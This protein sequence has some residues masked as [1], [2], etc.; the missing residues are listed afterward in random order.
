MHLLIALYIFFQSVLAQ[1][2]HLTT[3]YSS[4]YEP[5]CYPTCYRQPV[6]IIIDPQNLIAFVEGRNNSYCSGTADGSPSSIRLRRSN[7]GGITWSS[8]EQVLYTGKCDFLA[9]VQD[10]K[11]GRTHLFIQAPPTGSLYTYSDDKGVTW[12]SPEP[13]KIK[14]PSGYTW[15]PAVA[16]GIQISGEYCEEPTCNGLTGRLVISFVCYTKKA[17]DLQNQVES[18]TACPG[19]YTC[20]AVSDDQGATWT[21]HPEAV[22]KQEGSREASI[23]QLRSS[24]HKTK[25]PVIYATERNLG[26]DTGF[27][28]HAISV[29]G[30]TSFSIF[31]SDKE[32]PDSKVTNWTGIVAGAARVVRGEEQLVV[33]TTPMQKTARANMGIFVSSD[34]T[35]T[36][37]SGKL[38]FSG[39]AGYS[40]TWQLNST[41]VAILFENGVTEFA[42]RISFGLYEV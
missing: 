2:P 7:D 13:G 27:R 9:A 21:I 12:S 28:I 25:N 33:F 24:V 22:S 3:L 11:T 38:Y 18:D 37:G 36:W 8:P 31:G 17:E 26:D 35:E 34:E 30:G 19:C 41:H 40:D 42:Q 1:Q 5:H 4:C 23:V 15:T 39:P 6:L 32:L 10:F 29:D 16:H 20:L 14:G